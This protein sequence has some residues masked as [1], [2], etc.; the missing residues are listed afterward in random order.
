[1]A[2]LWLS[3]CALMER[4]AQGDYG[5]DPV[6]GTLPALEAT[7]RKA[8]PAVSLKQLFE[9]YA[10]SGASSPRTVAKWR[11]HVANFVDY[12]GHDDATKVTAAE[13]SSLR[14]K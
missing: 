3:L 11:P 2:D 12:L 7:P 13:R 9:D 8:K 1:M 4:R 14:S 10:V 6:E 5:A